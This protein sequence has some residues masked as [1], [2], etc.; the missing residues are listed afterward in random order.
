MSR[1]LETMRAFFDRGA[2][3]CE[4]HMKNNVKESAAFYREMAR[5]VPV[6]T[7]I[8]I[9]YLGCGTGLEIDE[10]FKL[11]ST[12]RVTGIDLSEKILENLRSKYEGKK[13]TTNLLPVPISKSNCRWRDSTLPFRFNRCTTSDKNKSYRSTGRFSAVRGVIE[14]ISKPFTLSVLRLRRWSCSTD[15]GL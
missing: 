7:G 5:L 12:A 4:S 2:Y 14:H 9:L 8:R 10:I 13:G 6:T 15:T 3:S 1:Y 11:N